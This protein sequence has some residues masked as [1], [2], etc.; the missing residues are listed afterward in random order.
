M[1]S[2]PG[3]VEAV[4]TAA[5]AYPVA[6]AS[7]SP[8]LVIDTI[9]ALTG[10]N[11]IFQ[12]IV[13]GDD[14]ARGKPAPD[15]YLETARRLNVSSEACVGIEDSANGLRALYA[16]K[17]KAIAVP[18]PG[19]SLPDDVLQQADLVLPSLEGFSL[20]LIASIV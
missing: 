20:S 1:P 8:T 11:R 17:M 2:L 7:G 12:T 16:A 15:I 5:S 19:F 13:Y 18:S 9:M 14:M 10:L 4:Y 3:A 6:L